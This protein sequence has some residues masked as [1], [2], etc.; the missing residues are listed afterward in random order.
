MT[1]EQ[2]ICFENDGE[3]LRGILHLPARTASG[4]PPGVV[5]LHG[6]SGC[7]LG[8]HRMFVKAARRFA[9]QGW[10]CLRFDFRGRGESDGASDRTTI[11][12]MISDTHGAIEFL[13]ARQTVRPV[14]LLGI[15]SG[16]KVAVAAA[17]SD[18]RAEGLVLWSAEPLGGLGGRPIRAGRSARVLREYAHKLARPETWRKL[19]RLQVHGK[20]VGKAILQAETP[21]RAERRDE[22]RLLEA[23]RA[24]GGRA[25]FVYGGNDPDTKR[26]AHTYRRFCRE[27]SI[28]HQFHEIAESNHSFYSLAWEHEA[29]ERSA[30]WLAR[31][32]AWSRT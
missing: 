4:P 8:P 19:L 5:F 3:T 30:A 31:L 15:C 13:R 16:G 9:A 32:H 25:L 11:H 20:L 14:V 1:T 23:F 17:A 28:A 29:I 26:A 21:D 24:F 6:W 22:D 12:S 27:N 7:R 2:A 10:M 18:A